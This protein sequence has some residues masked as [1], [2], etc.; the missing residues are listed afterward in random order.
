MI[1]CL[2]RSVLNRIVANVNL[3][4]SGSHWCRVHRTVR[5]SLY[6]M[7]PAKF[8][9]TIADEDLPHSPYEAAIL[10]LN[11]L[12][13]NAENIQKIREKRGLLQET[14]I[15]DMVLKLRKC[16]IELD[17]LDRLNVIHVSGT[18]G[19]GSTCAFVESIL[20]HLGFRTGL[21]T[22]PH[23][24]HARERIR[25]NGKP[26]S[27]TLFAK[28]FFTVYNKLKQKTDEGDMPPYFKF[29]TL[30]SFHVFIEECVDVAI[31]EVGIGGEY[32][33]TNVVQHPTVC[34]ITTLDIDHTSILG[35]TLT[36]IAWHKAGILKK[37]CPAI[38]T[39][40]C[41]QPLK[42]VTDR[43]EERGALLSIAPLYQYYTFEGGAV[44]AGI[45]GDHQKVNVSLA[46]QL[47]RAWLKQTQR[48]AEVFPDSSED[49]WEMGSSYFV[50]KS[51]AE[52]IES[53][54]WPGRSQIVLKDRIKYYLD[55]AHTPKSMEVCSKW[56]GDAVNKSSQKKRVM[57]FQC[58]ADRKP[59][60]L[61]PHL[62]R[63]AFDFALF[64]PTA[65]SVSP[66]I[67]SDLT[68]FN[69]SAFEQRKRSHLCASTWKEI[70]T[71]EVH[72]FDCISSTVDWIKKLSE[73]EELDVLVT[74]SLHLVGG[75]LSI[76]EPSID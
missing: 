12:Q 57:V 5:S 66:D 4:S 73:T 49:N 20:R 55:G 72:V 10:H 70:G 21:Y 42:V 29:L 68:N 2:H 33:A 8:A 39:P 37:G 51:M 35:T 30:L 26:I 76:I 59:S 53:C 6:A 25:I 38:V 74:G 1:D 46:L 58:T 16:G 47:A 71:G 24:V 64:C 56:F 52:A 44:S 15:P 41:E 62:S 7:L 17:A 60:S 31:V 23:L 19:K 67:K 65:L 63:H 75:V 54:H 40:L 45:A 34:G 32:D 61:L 69:A 14:N 50:P 9:H 27:E 36:E 22:S 28:H 3:A 48:E 11:S 13:S 18:K 43:A